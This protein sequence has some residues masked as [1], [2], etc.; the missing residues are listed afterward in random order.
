MPT[1]TTNVPLLSVRDLQTQF[2]TDQGVAT[3]TDGVSFDVGDRTTLGVVGESGCGKSVTARSILRILGA[4]GRITRGSINFRRRDGSVV[5][6]ARIDPRKGEI[7]RIRGGSISMIFQEPMATFSPVYTIGNQIMEAIT[8]HQKVDPGEAR[9]LAIEAL[10][11]VEIPRPQQRID[12]F[13]HQLSGGMLQRAMIAM[14][15][16][17][18]PQLLIADEPTTALDVTTQAQILALLRNLQAEIGMSII[19]IT[20]DLGVIAE[21]AERVVVMYLGK[22]VESAP[23]RE[24]FSNPLHPYTRALFRSIPSLAGTVLPRL[25]S[26]SGMVPDIYNTPAGCAFHPRCPQHESGLC[27]GRVPELLEVGPGH[28]V[29]C[30]VVEREQTGAPTIQGGARG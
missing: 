5:D 20:H 26:I 17:C 9:R 7:R 28:H 10:R 6:L 27:D 12:E 30:F 11:L 3:A 21:M 18:R 24:L 29:R 8:I 25:E 15:L 23:A 22:I 4:K 2:H 19:I 14:A 1:E 13:P 16:A